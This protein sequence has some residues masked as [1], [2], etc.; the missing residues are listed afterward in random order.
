MD[1]GT[2]IVASIIITIC[3]LPFLL[4]IINRK[5]KERQLLSYISN[6]AQ[7]HHSKLTQYEFCRDFVIGLDESASLFFF[8]KKST[9]TVTSKQINLE[10][11]ENCKVI[12]TSKANKAG[13]RGCQE[14]DKLELC[15]IPIPKNKPN[16]FLELYNSNESMQLGIEL[17][18]IEKWSKIINKKIVAL[19]ANG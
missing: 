12:R 16:I 1:T 2:T 9:D 19:K 15:F 5:K 6:I 13:N 14:I 3:I 11:I 17:P 4:L 8:L 7:E 18:L 10:G